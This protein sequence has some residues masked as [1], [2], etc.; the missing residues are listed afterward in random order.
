MKSEVWRASGKAP[1]RTFPTMDAPT[2]RYTDGTLRWQAPELMAG[3]NSKYL[4]PMDVYAFA[5][6][7]VEILNKGD[8]PWPL[9]DDETVRHLVLSAFAFIRLPSVHQSLTTCH[10]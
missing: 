2:H 3:G 10:R 9:L 4:A 6:C 8:L 1:P 7:C 5:I